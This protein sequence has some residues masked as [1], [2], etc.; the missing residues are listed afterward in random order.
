MISELK[1]AKFTHYFHAMDTTGDGLIREA[2]DRAAA[3]C[4]IS[5]LKI[6]AQSADAQA[7]K[8]S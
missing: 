4:V 8:T 1:R 3:D 6:D 2:D 7:L 5:V